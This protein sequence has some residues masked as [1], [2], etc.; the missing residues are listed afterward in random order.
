MSKDEKRLEKFLELLP[1]EWMV[2]F[3]YVASDGRYWGSYEDRLN[4]YSRYSKTIA[5]QFANP[6]I[7]EKYISLNKVFLELREFMLPNFQVD[8]IFNDDEEETYRI[9][10]LPELRKLSGNEN[11]NLFINKFEQFF[12]YFD[13]FEEEYKKFLSVAFQEI[14]EYSNHEII[15]NKQLKDC[16]I[17]FDNEKGKIFIDETEIELPPFKKEHVFTN[18]MFKHNKDELVDWSV[19][20]DEMEIPGEDYIH[21]EEN[22]RYIYDA[23]RD[24]NSR[25]MEAFNTKDKLFIVSAKT[26][27]RLY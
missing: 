10:L 22:W 24:V 26:I 16:V 2:D 13:N 17:R 20:Y 23:H 11:T 3:R 21:K 1:E 25:V 4:E 8:R 5:S 7:N 19:V 12:K 18:V 15:P 9:A 6:K 27:K 14:G